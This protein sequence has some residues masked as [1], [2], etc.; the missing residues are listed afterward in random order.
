MNSDM[1]QE[2]NNLTA[3]IRVSSGK[4]LEGAKHKK[5]RAIKNQR[6]IKD[7]NQTQKRLKIF[8]AL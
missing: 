4:R 7:I 5:L 1:L 8:C 6:R 2:H 3:T